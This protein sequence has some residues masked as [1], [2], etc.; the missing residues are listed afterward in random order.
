MMRMHFWKPQMC[1]KD[2]YDRQNDP[3]VHMPKWVQAYA[4][5]LCGC[6][7]TSRLGTQSISRC[8]RGNYVNGPSNWANEVWKE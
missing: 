2:K 5:N 3:R 6:T 1:L 8:W 4:N 7:W